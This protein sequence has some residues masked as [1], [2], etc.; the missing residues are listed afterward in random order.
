M[1]IMPVSAQAFTAMQNLNIGDLRHCENGEIRPLLSSLVRMS[2][3]S[4]LDNTRSTIE[5]RKQ[6]LSLLVA[7]E[8]VNNI[9]SLLQINYLELET[10]V[11][12]E[13]QLRQKIGNSNQDSAQ[14]HG[15]QNGV[16]LGFERADE[17][18][19]V[20]I[21][22]SELFY[23]QSQ[24][25][26]QN[27]QGVARGPNENIIKQSELFDNEIY[28]EEITDIICIALAELPSLFNIQEV[29]ETLLYV[30]NG[31]TIICWVVA[32]MPDCFK[33]GKLTQK[34]YIL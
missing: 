13:Q 26:E 7:L 31:S 30:N 25:I 20:R 2:L 17:T 14:F 15:L 6:I 21:V 3:L 1:N 28:L 34:N 19:K 9:V 10:D 18:R 29:I 22:L 27:Q 8:E 5:M 32:N 11:R 23:I 12:K 4:P 24:I 33:E 16:A